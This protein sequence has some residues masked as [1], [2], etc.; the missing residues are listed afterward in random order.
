MFQTKTEIFT[1][2]ES[3]IRSY[4]NSFPTVF[5][6]AFGSQLI[7]EQGHQYIDFFAGASSLNYGHNNPKFKKHLLNYIESGGIVQSL[8]MFTVAKR[9]FIERFEQVI[10][11]PR[12]LEYRF[13]FP[14][15]T[16]T[17][18]V[19]AAIKLA[20]KVTGQQT[21]ASFQGG[22]HGVTL[23]SLAITTNPYYRQAAGVPL[24]YSIFLPFH[25][26]VGM[27]SL[28]IN[29][30]QEIID[31][32]KRQCEKPA[33]CILETVQAEGG[34]NVASVTWLK[35]LSQ[36]LQAEKILLIVDDIQVGCGRT[37]PF[38]S[39]ER[40]GLKP[41]IIC[42]SKSLSGYGIPLSMVLIRADLDCWAPGEHNGTFRGHNLAFV[43]AKA[44][45]D[46]WQTPALEKEIVQKATIINDRL[47]KL[48][49]NYTDFS[50]VLGIGLIQGIAWNPPE[51]A[52]QISQQA[53]ERGLI[54]ETAGH[55][56]EVLKL[57]PPLTIEP[58]LLHEGLNILEASVTA[59]LMKGDIYQ[60]ENRQALNKL[61]G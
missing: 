25:N 60:A 5:S 17:N 8:D 14:G 4:C 44:A 15:P 38:F 13:M 35:Q 12:G 21:I 30:V 6:K 9:E 1:R 11:K 53:F 28:E 59:T 18:A 33:A 39:F 58:Y 56:N 49:A 47:K 24:N 46:Y 29:K 55:K 19:E 43:T 20:R 51:L 16:G 10:L 45:L 61:T 27:E 3:N 42:L 22:F 7:D 32:L 54:L 34:I 57:L 37:G 41:D 50:N 48:M 31:N 23:G 52:K 26:Q 2:L 36:L 40:A